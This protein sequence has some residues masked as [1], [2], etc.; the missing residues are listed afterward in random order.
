MV[1]RIIDSQSETLDYLG[2]LLW[3]KK[4]DTRAIEKII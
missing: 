4:A 3:N 1:F 2:L